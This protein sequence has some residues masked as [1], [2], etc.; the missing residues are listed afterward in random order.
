MLAMGKVK[1]NSSRVEASKINSEVCLRQRASS[2]YHLTGAVLSWGSMPKP[3]D[4][5]YL[6]LTGVGHETG[7][8]TPQEDSAEQ[9]FAAWTVPGQE[10]R[11]SS[12]SVPSFISAVT[13]QR[14]QIERIK[15]L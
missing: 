7:R 10:S 15:L 3:M 11:L 1:R 8:E 9:D 14:K 2:T 6:W 13:L 5:I 12:L 4:E